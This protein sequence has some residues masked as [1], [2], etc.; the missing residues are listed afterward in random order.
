MK[1]CYDCTHFEVYEGWCG[2]DVTPGNPPRVECEK[3]H[4]TTENALGSRGALG[5]C[6]RQAEN[7]TDYQED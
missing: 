7:C 3:G 4:F 2:T 1:M 5:R 6:L